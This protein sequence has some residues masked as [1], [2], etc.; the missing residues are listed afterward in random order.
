MTK[1]ILRVPDD[2]VTMYLALHQPWHSVR[3]LSL[4]RIGRHCRIRTRRMWGAASW[5]AGVGILGRAPAAARWTFNILP[6]PPN[7]PL[8]G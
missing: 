6:P 8:P 1:R 7:I 5:C 3:V 2:R 4:K